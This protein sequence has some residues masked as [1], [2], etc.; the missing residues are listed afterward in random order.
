[1]KKRERICRL[2]V[3]LALFSVSL[4]T[5]NPVY[6]EEIPLIELQREREFQHF[7]RE[8]SNIL[9][10][11]E[12]RIVV[13]DGIF[14]DIDTLLNIRRPLPDLPLMISIANA[15]NNRL[16]L[17]EIKL[18]SPHKEEVFSQALYRV[19]EPVGREIHQM[20]RLR[21]E[22]EGVKNRAHIWREITPLV[23]HF[24]CMSL[25]ANKVSEAISLLWNCHGLRNEQMGL[26]PVCVADATGRRP[27]FVRARNDIGE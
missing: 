1:M 15:T 11:E 24:Y 18:Y 8:L 9:K 23:V 19:L 21:E 13:K 6:G 17:K 7:T 12:E 26:P 16:T 5:L 22:I 20:K 27:H 10:E 3:L 14:V 25:R 2:W 4:F